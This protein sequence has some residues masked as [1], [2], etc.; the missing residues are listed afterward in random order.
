MQGKSDLKSVRLEP[1][2]RV[3]LR[4][5]ARQ[6]GVSES[7]FIR[8]AIERRAHAVLS[9]SI[10]A[11]LADVIGIAHGRGPSVAHRTGEAFTEILVEKKKTRWR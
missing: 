2:L 5:A 1:E 8:D 3:R 6:T 10:A 9:D 11:R 7:Q 4:K